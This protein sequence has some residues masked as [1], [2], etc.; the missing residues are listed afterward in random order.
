V[1]DQKLDKP[2]SDR[3]RLMGAV[4]RFAERNDAG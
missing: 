3:E 1:L 2:V 4:R